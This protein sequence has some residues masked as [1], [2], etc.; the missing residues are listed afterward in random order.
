MPK[1]TYDQVV[2]IR[3]FDPV[4]VT[5][6]PISED[7]FGPFSRSVAYKGWNRSTMPLVWFDSS[8]ERAIANIVDGDRAIA[9]WVRLLTN[10]LP[11]L[12]NNGGQNYNPDFIV[13][14]N[15]E[16]H[17]VVEAKMNKEMT[18]A[19]VIGKREAA[20]R[21]ANH[22][23]ADESVADEWKYLLV[24]EAD[25]ATARGSWLALKKWEA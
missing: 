11:I 1:P 15:E 20:M 19:D 8:T 14:E 23:T 24:S 6:R 21:W 5:D 2:Q 7:R 9:W 4:R 13:I 10:D 22:V 16:T 18:S 3:D 12:W 17:W 25:V